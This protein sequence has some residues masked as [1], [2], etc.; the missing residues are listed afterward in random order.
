MSRTY[1]RRAFNLFLFTYFLFL[2]QK[3]MVSLLSINR[4]RSS[5][6][7]RKYLGDLIEKW[8]LHGTSHISLWH[9]P[10]QVSVWFKRQKWLL[11]MR[12][13]TATSAR[14]KKT[15][16]EKAR[17]WTRPST[18]VAS[19]VS[20]LVP[21]VPRRLN[22]ADYITSVIR[23]R[24]SCHAGPS[25]FRSVYAIGNAPFY[26]SVHYSRRLAMESRDSSAT[27]FPPFAISSR[28]IW[29]SAFICR[30]EI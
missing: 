7:A 25:K 27:K 30:L 3:R 8:T 24:A 18:R 5:P 13:F 19:P 28:S 12:N 29:P 15:R 11:W 4:F 2:E 20:T 22:P 26:P 9:I 23:S 6:R 17:K 16:A 14:P 10:S 21:F 1:D